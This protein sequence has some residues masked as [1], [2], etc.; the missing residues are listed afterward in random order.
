MRWKERQ[1]RVEEHVYDAIH[2]LEDEFDLELDH[3]PEVR[4]FG[5]NGYFED[6]GLPEKYREDVEENRA[7]RGSI[8]LTRPKMVIINRFCPY[9]INEEAAHYFH[10]N[11]SDIKLTHLTKIDWLTTV[12][13]T[14]MFGFF[15]S[16]IVD[17]S[18][19]N[20]QFKNFPDHVGMAVTNPSEF[21]SALAC[22]DDAEKRSNMNTIIYKQAYELG[23]RLFFAY[24]MGIIS[25]QRVQEFLSRDFSK[26]G[27]S[28]EYFFNLRSQFWPLV[29]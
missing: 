20:D 10:L 2:H 21:G 15:G 8:Y 26:K 25:K 17:C 5:R 18:R 3:L 16:K 9:H 24:E 12:I 29:K 14:E 7:S 22:F 19:E 11:H 23:D 27:E 1:R 28:T 4:W 6:L 13:L